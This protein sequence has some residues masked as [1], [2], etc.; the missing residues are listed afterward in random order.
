MGSTSKRFWTGADFGF[1]IEHVS[2]GQ[3]GFVNIA[4]NT[5]RI[6]DLK[7][8]HCSREA[9]CAQSTANGQNSIRN[10]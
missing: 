6:S 9:Q 7:T 2:M 10:L 8:S 1:K 5:G 3:N 4:V